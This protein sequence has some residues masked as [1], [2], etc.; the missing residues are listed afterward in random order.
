MN[1]EAFPT[2]GQFR[3]QAWCNTCQD[4]YNGSRVPAEDWR[5]LHN[6]LKHTEEGTK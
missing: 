2:A 5:D 3:F 1:A 4:G 6:R